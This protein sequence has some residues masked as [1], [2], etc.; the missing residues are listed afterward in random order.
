MS[1]DDNTYRGYR[2]L[3]RKQERQNENA[4]RRAVAEWNRKNKRTPEHQIPVPEGT[5]KQRMAEYGRLFQVMVGKAPVALPTQDNPASKNEETSGGSSTGDTFVLKIYTAE[6]GTG[7]IAP[8]FSPS[9][10]SQDTLEANWIWYV[11]GIAYLT[12]PVGFPSD[13]PIRTAMWTNLAERP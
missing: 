7:V 11:K 10:E 9:Q 13:A 3:E 6:V 8:Y 1:V 4:A 5:H 2:N 12:K